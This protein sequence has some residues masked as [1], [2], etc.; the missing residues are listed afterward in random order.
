MI[1]RHY[2][3]E[4]LIKSF[5]FHFGFC[6]PGSTNNW[7]AVYAL[8]AL[9]EDL[10]LDMIAHPFETRS[11]SFYFVED[12]LIMHNKAAYKYF[13]EDAAQSKKSYEDKFGSKAAKS[14]KEDDKVA[15]AK[16]TGVAS[17]VAL[18]ADA[19]SAAG[20]GVGARTTASAKAAS[21]AEQWSKE[22]DYY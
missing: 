13:R 11:D 1:E 20:G 3:R 16:A 21:K 18:E 7:D 4:K 8:P 15:G 22:D 17:G 5:D 9:S 14:S 2:F 10:I 6:I 12:R 19:K